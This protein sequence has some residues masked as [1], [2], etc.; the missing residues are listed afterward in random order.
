MCHG[1]GVNMTFRA[2]F[3]TN[4]TFVS[5]SQI[6]LIGPLIVED[7]VVNNAVT[8]SSCRGRKVCVLPR[9]MSLFGRIYVLDP[10][11]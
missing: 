5:I 3:L 6:S 1:D 8:G 10:H 4:F 9:C 7:C 11:R 2:R